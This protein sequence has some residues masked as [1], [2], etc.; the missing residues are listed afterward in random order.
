MHGAMETHPKSTVQTLRCVLV[1]HMWFAAKGYT[2]LKACGQVS[3]VSVPAG[4]GWS[5][6]CSIPTL[7]PPCFACQCVWKCGCHSLMRLKMLMQII[8]HIHTH[9]HTCLHVI[10]IICTLEMYGVSSTPQSIACGKLEVLKPYCIGKLVAWVKGWKLLGGLKYRLAATK[11][12]IWIL[13]CHPLST[14]YACQH[15]GYSCQSGLSL[16]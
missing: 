12:H 7:L 10:Y 8:A 11:S 5:Y 14:R 13:S 4:T 9:I 16:L 1:P 15:E 6:P 3:P 2:H